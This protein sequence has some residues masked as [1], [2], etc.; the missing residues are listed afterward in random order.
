MSF[1]LVPNGN[2]ICTGSVKM[3][4]KKKHHLSDSV[5]ITI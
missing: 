1:V 5:I 4:N 2:I 3:F